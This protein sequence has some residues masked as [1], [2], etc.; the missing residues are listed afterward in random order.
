M[1]DIFHDF[2]IKAPRQK[3]FQA[4]STP[5]GLAAWWAKRAMGEPVEGTV[6]ELGFG[7]DYE[8]RAVVLRCVPE[9]EFELKLTVA[10]EDWRATRVGFQLNERE[11]VTQVHFHHTGWPEA[12]EHYRIS[13]FCWAMYLRLLKRYV[14][15]GE[16]VPYEVRL[17][18]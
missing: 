6:Y 15:V 13:C 2:P 16:I 12:S 4:I 3:V 5:V 9:A 14:E 8:W 11:G 7:P 17:D 10:M 18:V 1:A